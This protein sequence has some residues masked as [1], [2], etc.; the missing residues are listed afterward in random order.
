MA[1]NKQHLGRLLA[2][3]SAFDLNTNR[4]EPLSL[5]DSHYIDSLT[6]RNLF[7]RKD[8]NVNS[9]DKYGRT[10]LLIAAALSN[11]PVLK[12]LIARRDLNPNS[13]DILGRSPLSHA[14]AMGHV[15]ATSALIGRTDIDVGRRD[16]MERSPIWWSRHGTRGDSRKIYGL[17]QAGN[18]VSPGQ[19]FVLALLRLI[20]RGPY[21]REAVMREYEKSDKS[22]CKTAANIER[23]F[24]KVSQ[25]IVEEDKKASG[26]RGDGNALRRE[27]D[28]ACTLKRKFPDDD[29]EET[30]L[31]GNKKGSTREFPGSMN[32]MVLLKTPQAE[33]R[34]L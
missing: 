34:K 29:A 6:A 26:R 3:H 23:C 12:T 10:A 24:Q 17:A 16:K 8:I 19:V 33:D 31:H 11:E 13:T 28:H 30:K 22:L 5:A 2:K 7:Q 14:A 20:D 4:I 15:H 27:G 1:E 32:E 18:F 9:K 21:A 25:I